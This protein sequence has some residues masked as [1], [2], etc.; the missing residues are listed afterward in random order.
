MNFLC[1]LGIHKWTK[2]YIG[3]NKEWKIIAI[4]CNRFKCRYGYDG[5]SALLNHLGYK[6]GYD[7]GTFT[8]SYYD[9]CEINKKKVIIYI[10]I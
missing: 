10:T 1:K 3:K 9:K 8:K 5:I 2:V 7:F 6:K 4:Y